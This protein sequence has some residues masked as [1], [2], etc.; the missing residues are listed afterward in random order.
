M[1]D[2]DGYNI[3]PTLNAEKDKEKKNWQRAI[4]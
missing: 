4:Y 3:Y 2:N 1:Q